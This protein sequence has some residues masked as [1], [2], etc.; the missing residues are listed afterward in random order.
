MKRILSMFLAVTL[1]ATMLSC[2]CGL[3]VSAATYDVAEAFAS[4]TGTSDDPYVIETVEQ[5]ALLAQKVNSADEND[6]E[7]ASACYK[8][9]ANIVMNE[10]VLKSDNMVNGTISKY[11]ELRTLLTAAFRSYGLLSETATK[12]CF[13]ECLTV[14]VILSAECIPKVVIADSLASLKTPL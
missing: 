2:V 14:T 8:L 7:Y 5:L 12:L 1:I 9:G 4:G 10:N 11:G 13:R 3:S 6:A